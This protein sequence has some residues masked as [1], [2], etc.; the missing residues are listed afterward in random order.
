[1]R[2]I[3]PDGYLTT[4]GAAHIIGV[5]PSTVRRWCALGEIDAE[6]YHGLWLVSLEEAERLELAKRA[7]NATK[8][9]A[10]R[11]RRRA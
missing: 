1:M 5:S 8:R 6:V 7:S 3:L 10:R 2:S 11:R 4:T 9:K